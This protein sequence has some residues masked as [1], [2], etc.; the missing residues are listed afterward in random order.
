MRSSSR[1]AANRAC[2]DEPHPT[3]FVGVLYRELLPYADQLAGAVHYAV[4]AEASLRGCATGP[5]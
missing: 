5:P 3:G 2:P 1:A 4:R